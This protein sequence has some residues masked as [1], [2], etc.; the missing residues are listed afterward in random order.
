MN[1]DGHTHQDADPQSERSEP[2]DRLLPRQHGG[3]G[4]RGTPVP[5][6]VQRE[7]AHSEAA[8]RGLSVVHEF[9]DVASGARS[10]REQYQAMLAYLR[11]GGAGTVLIQA[12]DRLGRDQRELLTAAWELED[13]GVQLVAIDKEFDARNVID[14]AIAPMLAQM[15]SLGTTTR[16]PRT[17]QS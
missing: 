1:P 15:M 2:C 6:N 17:P 16:G 4:R 10:N 8:K 14:A 13:L 7:K 3:A 11:T 9:V 5:L 12:L